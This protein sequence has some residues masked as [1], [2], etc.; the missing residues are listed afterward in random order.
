MIYYLRYT[1]F[2][3]VVGWGSGVSSL[4]E[5]TPFLLFLFEVI[6]QLLNPSAS[7]FHFVYVFL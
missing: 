2:R 3:A 7:R 5:G 6:L 4:L 1:C